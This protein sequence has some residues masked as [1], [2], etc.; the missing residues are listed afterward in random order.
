MLQRLGDTLVRRRWWVLGATLIFVGSPAGWGAV[1][2]KNS[3]G[4]FRDPNARVGPG[5]SRTGRG[6][7]DRDPNVVLLVTA[8]DGDVNDPAVAE[9][10]MALT[11]ALSQIDGVSD[12]ASY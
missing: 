10:G 1:S 4:R 9:A 12:V 8:A 11:S 7:R 6:F 3:R 5:R 2:P